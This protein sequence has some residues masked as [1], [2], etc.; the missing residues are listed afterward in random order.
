LFTFFGVFDVETFATFSIG[1][2]SD[3]FGCSS[4]FEIE[5]IVVEWLWPLNL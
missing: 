4:E 2:E 1:V 3:P 5:E